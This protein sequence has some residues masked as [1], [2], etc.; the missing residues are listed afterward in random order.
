[1]STPLKPWLNHAGDFRVTPRESD[2][3]SYVNEY[4]RLNN[5]KPGG[6]IWRW[7]EQTDNPKGE[8]HDAEFH[9]ASRE[10]D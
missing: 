2:P 1:M 9:S 5:I 3:P 8:K 6:V 7:S 10:P 4:Y